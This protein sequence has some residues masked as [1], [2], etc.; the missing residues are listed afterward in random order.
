MKKII[1][2]TLLFLMLLITPIVADVVIYDYVTYMS[3]TGEVL[4]LAWDPPEGENTAYLTY[5]IRLKHVEQGI[6][7]P[8]T[9]TADTQT[10][11]TLPKVGHY[12]V[13]ARSIRTVPGDDPISGD[14]GDSVTHG[15]VGTEVRSWWLYGKLD[16]PGQI[17]IGK[18]KKMFFGVYK[19]VFGA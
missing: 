12:I 5:E 1:I 14:W 19:S 4:T 6:Y 13:E 3:N 9:T 15:M 7:I 11:L 18:I 10:T 2:S 17:I 8:V 16:S